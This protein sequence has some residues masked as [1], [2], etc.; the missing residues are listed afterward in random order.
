MGSVLTDEQNFMKRGLAYFT[1][2]NGS[3]WHRD[4]LAPATADLQR[5]E[6]RV[7]ALLRRRDGVSQQ[8]LAGFVEKDLVAAITA[9]DDIVEVKT[10]IFNPYDESVWP[11]VGVSHDH[12]TKQQYRGAVVLAGVNRIA[13]KQM[14]GSEAFQATLDR[15]GKMFECLHSIEAKNTVFMVDEGKLLLPALR[16]FAIAKILSRIG[17]TSQAEE[18][19]LSQVLSVP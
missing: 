10:A 1:R 13:V 9:S 8:D 16:G 17:A 5:P 2:G 15:Q 3:R 6:T 19:V 7:I 14:F 4:I 12:P 18:P 11:A